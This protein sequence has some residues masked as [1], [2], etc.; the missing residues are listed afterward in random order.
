MRDIRWDVKMNT[1]GTQALTYLVNELPQDIAGQI[2]VLNILEDDGYV[3]NVGMKIDDS[4]YWVE[5][6]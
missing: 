3:A 2:A 4:T 5:R 6:G 1:T